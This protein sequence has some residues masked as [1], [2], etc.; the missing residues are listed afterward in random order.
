MTEQRHAE[1]ADKEPT[2]LQ[3]HMA[4][5]IPEVTGISVE[6]YSSV[7]EA[8]NEGVRLGVALRM[9]YQSSAE[10]RERTAKEREGRE[11][12]AEKLRAERKEA[13]AKKDQE[14]E[15]ARLKREQ[16]KKDRAEAK[17]AKEAADAEAKEKAAKAAPVV[18]DEDD[19]EEDDSAATE[20]E[21]ED[22]A[23]PA[24]KTAKP[25]RA[26]PAAKGKADLF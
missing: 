16:E 18:E 9:P 25:S 15:E 20:S 3:A 7:T 1:Y 26:K 21:N 10:N 4:T 13:R 23:V 11:E 19:E 24:A 17:A 5:W 14:L 12:A 22:G 2:A 8:F 6:D